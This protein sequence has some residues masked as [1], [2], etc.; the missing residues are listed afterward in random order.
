MNIQPRST[1]SSSPLN[2][3]HTP[4]PDTAT[5]IPQTSMEHM[6]LYEDFDGHPPS[7]IESPNS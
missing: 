2:T 5:I 3:P 7:Y 4:V 1:S 6:K